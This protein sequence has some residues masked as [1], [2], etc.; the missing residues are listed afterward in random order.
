MMKR[1]GK[2]LESLEVFNLFSSSKM[3]R[4]IFERYKDELYVGMKTIE[5]FNNVSM[6]KLFLHK[7]LIIFS[8]IFPTNKDKPARY[9]VLSMTL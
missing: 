4:N 8:E 9:E 5:E 1:N 2:V 3:M 6:E 7:A